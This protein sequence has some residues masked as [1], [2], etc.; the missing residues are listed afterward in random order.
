MSFQRFLESILTAGKIWGGSGVRRPC[1]PSDG[2]KSSRKLRQQGSQLTDPSS[3]CSSASE[4]D[5][6][7]AATGCGE[8]SIDEDS[9]NS[10]ESHAWPNSKRTNKFTKNSRYYATKR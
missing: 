2:Q 9:D 10:E 5:D 1:Q 6:E 7:D 8:S 3:A 4:S